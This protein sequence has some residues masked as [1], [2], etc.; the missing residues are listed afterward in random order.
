MARDCDLLI[1]GGGPSGLSAAINGASE[2][3]K[4]VLLDAALQLGGQA[5][6]SHAIENYPMP[7][8]YEEG[9]TGEKLMGGF[10]RQAVKFQTEML[11][12]VRASS[13]SKDRGCWMVETEDFQEFA[14]RAVI[15]APGL[16]YRRHEARGLSPYL[17]RNVFYG[18][19]PNLSNLLGCTV[20]VVGGANS[21]GQ[22]V[23]RLARLRR[24][25]VKVLCRRPL[26]ETMSTYLIERIE[27]SHKYGT[28]DAVIEVV[29]GA[30]VLQIFGKKH[31]TDLCYRR[32]GIVQSI[33]ADHLLFYIG[34]VPQ[35]AWLRRTVDLD[36]HNFILTG[37]DLKEPKFHTLAFETS[38]PGIF[39][40]GDVRFGSTKRIANATGE[41]AGG[42][43]M[44]H[45]IAVACALVCDGDEASYYHPV[46]V[47]A[48]PQPAF[49]TQALNQTEN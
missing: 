49:Q 27:K 34:A 3:L 2:G 39:A 32:N 38:C 37:P 11:N 42:L 5:R 17:G 28:K 36:D 41:G 44:V 13:I 10:I 45:S 30:E 21:A 33:P 15:L 24:A 22:A 4:V 25:K 29:D 16:N 12:P 1:V 43:Q 20:V 19:P 46:E 9:T 31:M 6:E 8:G 40:V 7:D 35:T 26:R 48:L 18:M 14:A 23:L 47:L